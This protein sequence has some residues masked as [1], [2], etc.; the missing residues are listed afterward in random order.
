MTGGVEGERLRLLLDHLCGGLTA[1]GARA[2][3]SLREGEGAVS[4]RVGSAPQPSPLRHAGAKKLRE[5]CYEAAGALFAA[6]R[7][8]RERHR[9]DEG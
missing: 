6:E 8:V 5:S 7:A 3:R 4:K 2:D 1:N 9:A